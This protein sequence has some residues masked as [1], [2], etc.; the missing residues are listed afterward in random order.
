MAVSEMTLARLRTETREVWQ[1]N[2]LNGV[3]AWVRGCVEG[4]DN[5]EFEDFE[6]YLVRRSGKQRI[7]KGDW[8]LRDL[9]DV[10]PEWVDDATFQREY[11]LT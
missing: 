3:P 2:H 1:Y 9:D 11:E 5:G 4:R 10:D 7:E 6:L 8:L